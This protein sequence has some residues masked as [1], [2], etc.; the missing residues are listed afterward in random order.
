[1]IAFSPLDN[2][3]KLKMNILNLFGIKN[4][5]FKLLRTKGIIDVSIIKL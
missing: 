5:H 2:V 1:M 3:A 4:S